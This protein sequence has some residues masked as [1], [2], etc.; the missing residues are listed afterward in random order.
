MDKVRIDISSHNINGFKN[1]YLNLRCESAPN[2]IFCI[3]EHWLR[4][5]YKKVRSINQLRVVHPLFD[6]Y[7]VSAM[8]ESHYQKV[9]VGRGYGGTGFIFNKKY[10]PFLKPLIQYESD[11]L[12]VLEIKDQDRSILL[13]NVYFPYKQSSEDHRIQYLE[14]LGRVENVLMS[15]PTARFI[16]VGDFNY[17]LYENRQPMS[18]ATNDLL[19]RFDLMC[20]HDLDPTFCRNNS[21]TRCC[22]KNNSYSLLDY[23]FFSRPLQDRVKNC[24]IHY[25]GGNPSDH[26]PVHLELE[27]VPQ[28]AGD[29]NAS[30]TQAGKYTSVNWSTV[31]SDDL[32]MYEAVMEELLDSLQVPTNILHG[33]KY[34]SHAPHI[35]NVKLIL[36]HW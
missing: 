19:D 26:F 14:I 1:D 6:G 36:K 31:Q 10:A 32:L 21:Y 9:N 8:N 34:C 3:Q 23:I 7:G 22:E 18:K 13:I 11:R 16:I 20:S 27:V 25:D 17:D 30:D 15:N 28:C 24:R 12:T 33:D 29:S 5:T 35:F 2:S 4:P